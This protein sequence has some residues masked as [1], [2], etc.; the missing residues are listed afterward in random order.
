VEDD[1]D[2]VL[3]AP[4]RFLDRLDAAEV[5][6]LGPV[7]GYP[8]EVDRVPQARLTGPAAA[9]PAVGFPFG[10]RVGT[11]RHGLARPVDVHRQG[12]LVT[13]PAFR[14]GPELE[15]ITAVPAQPAQ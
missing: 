8:P 13:F 3:G 11:D 4:V 15:P 12:A 6:V 14:V 9:P 10:R 5:P 1:V 7:V 2:E